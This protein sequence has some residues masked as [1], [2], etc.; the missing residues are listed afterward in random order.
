MAR[1]VVPKEGLEALQMGPGAFHE[2]LTRLGSVPGGCSTARRILGSAPDF[3][4]AGLESERW[5][6]SG[7]IS[8]GIWLEANFQMW[9]PLEASIQHSSLAEAIS[10]TL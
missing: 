5:D 2:I 6:P 8:G 4:R 1:T 10:H 9:R 7:G 3:N